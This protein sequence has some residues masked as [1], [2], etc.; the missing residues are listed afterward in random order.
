MWARSLWG[1]GPNLS[2][3][4]QALELGRDMCSSPGTVLCQA[5]DGIENG[6]KVGVGSRVPR[7]KSSNY[8][9]LLRWP[10]SPGPGPCGAMASDIL[11]GH[12]WCGYIACGH[13][14]I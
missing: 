8:F 14:N 2:P 7:P 11:A 4:I 13:Q 1:L 12:F 6:D 3:F 10:P 9:L 5:D